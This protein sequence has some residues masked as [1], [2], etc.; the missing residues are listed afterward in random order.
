VK[1]LIMPDA[2]LKFI[3]EQ[4]EA[5]PWEGKIPLYHHIQ[6][7]LDDACRSLL[8][9]GE[10]LPDEKEYFAGQKIRWVAG[11]REGALSPRSDD[12]AARQAK[13]EEIL[14][15]MYE[16]TTHPSDQARAK[17][18]KI[19]MADNLLELVDPL[20][21]AIST[22]Q[23]L[24]AM[25]LYREARWMASQATHRGVVKA[26]IALLGLYDTEDNTD[27]LT[28]LGK[29]DEFTLYA[30]VALFNT[31][32]DPAKR[33][34]RLWDLAQCVH[35]WGKIELV[36]RLALLSEAQREDFKA[37]LLRHGCENEV[38][39]EYLAHT[40]A[41]AGE[42]AEAL[43]AEA[44]D[45]ELLRGAGIIITALIHGGPAK[46][47]EDYED[48]VL[49]AE[50]FLYHLRSRA[51][52]LEHLNQACAIHNFLIDEE[53]EWEK[54]AEL[55]WT[56]E[57]RSLLIAQCEEIL[58]D[59]KWPP[60]ISEA[61]DDP[62]QRW[63]ASAAANH[64]NIEVWEKLF[65]QLKAAPLDESLYY[66]LMETNDA[67]RVDRV[68]TFAAQTLPLDE[69]AGGPA[70]ELFGSRAH[71]CL[72]FILQRLGKFPGLGW[73]LLEA[74][75]KSPVVRN[76]HWALNVLESWGKRRWPQTAWEMLQQALQVEPND[77]VKERIQ[78][79]LA[80]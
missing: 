21:K 59:P 62:Q 53:A 75:L 8:P 31:L 9:E 12:E 24:P 77:E 44:I 74:G 70:D 42:L 78:K 5:L 43:E 26:G 76:R 66:E 37:W 80:E 56:P 45:D 34:D 11:A 60:M 15:A 46:D 3:S 20:L 48:G 22:R 65:V 71:H 41:A 36:E 58:H 25:P 69:M 67:N 10:E 57:K 50:R 18:Y 39:D 19:F 38:M 2:D 72:D 79:L 51:G 6:A 32:R 64:L 17:V 4:D 16:L 52:T 63:L 23:V 7:N 14:H 54:R 55:G 61:I 28:T 40:C 47:M 68:V 49:A 27:L 29:H 35:G 1:E 13:V 33:F 73:P 30:I